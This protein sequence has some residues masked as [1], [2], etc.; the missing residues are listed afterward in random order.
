MY[1]Y[2]YTLYICYIYTKC[3]I[4]RLAWLMLSVHTLCTAISIP[5]FLQPRA[6]RNK[7]MLLTGTRSVDDVSLGRSDKPKTDCGMT[8][9]RRCIRIFHFNPERLGILTAGFCRLLQVCNIWTPYGHRRICGD[10]KGY[11]LCRCCPLTWWFHLVTSLQAWSFDLLYFQ[12]RLE[13]YWNYIWIGLYR[14]CIDWTKLDKLVRVPRLQRIKQADEG[15]G[16]VSDPLFEVADEQMPLPSLGTRGH[17]KKCIWS[18]NKL[19]CWGFAAAQFHSC[20]TTE[21]IALYI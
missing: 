5:G 10:V 4:T 6:S 20:C 11:S 21:L 15:D 7:F 19:A 14:D 13:Y 2:T 1:T 18:A 8:I 16:N 12:S 3:I 17:P 9:Q